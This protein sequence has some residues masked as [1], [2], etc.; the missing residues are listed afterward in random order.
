MQSLVFL[1][2]SATKLYCTPENVIDIILEFAEFLNGL[3]VSFY[4]QFKE[5]TLQ[6][7]P[8][9]VHEVVDQ[10]F[11]AIYPDIS[12]F[13][14]D[15]KKDFES[16]G[17]IIL[18]AVRLQLRSLFSSVVPDLLCWFSDLCS[19]PFIQRDDDR[20]SSPLNS[21]Q[22]KGFVGKNTKAV[23]L[24]VL[25][26]IVVEHMEAMVPEVPRVVQSLVFWA[27]FTDFEPTSAFHDYMCGF[28]SI[29][30][31]CK[32]LLSETLRVWGVIPPRVQLHSDTITFAPSDTSISHSW[33]LD[34]PSNNIE[35]DICFSED[36]ESLISKLNPPIK[37]ILPSDLALDFPAN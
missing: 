3:L 31:S 26:S 23:I 25:E 14:P 30:E 19:W 2:H 35:E 15:V 33:F 28:Q 1:L 27:A 9:K 4:Y 12:H 11:R 8:V 34:D 21:S 13:F 22:Y 16:F 32:L 37:N 20:V 17:Q 36:V 6:L 7:D 10:S 5:G 18:E 24:Y 29:M